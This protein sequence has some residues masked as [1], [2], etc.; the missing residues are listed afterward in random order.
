M[1]ISFDDDF[2]KSFCFPQFFE[3]IHLMAL[4][5]CLNIL[6]GDENYLIP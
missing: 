1:V 3:R 4:S 5:S 6:L 2:S